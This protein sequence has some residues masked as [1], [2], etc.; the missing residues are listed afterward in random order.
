MCLS[1]YE[2]YSSVLEKLITYEKESYVLVE[3]KFSI[4]R[5]I[6]FKDFVY[7]FIK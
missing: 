3:N 2:F 4:H 6:V 5:E 7:Y 1:T